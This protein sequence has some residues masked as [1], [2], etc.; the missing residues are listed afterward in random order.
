MGWC[1]GAKGRSDRD[2]EAAIYFGN[3]TRDYA[4]WANTNG[5]GPS[6]SSPRARSTRET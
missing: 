2:G 4:Y 6:S 5:T 1:Y 3:Y